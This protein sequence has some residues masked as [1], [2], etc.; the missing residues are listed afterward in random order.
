MKNQNFVGAALLIA[1]TFAVSSCNKD[2]FATCDLI[3]NTSDSTFTTYEYNAD[4]NIAKVSNTDQT[5]TPNTI[6]ATAYTYNADK[7]MTKSVQTLNGV[8]Q[9]ANEYT[10]NADGNATL[11]KE[12]DGLGALNATHNLRYNADKLLAVDSLVD[13][14]GSVI[15]ATY[16]YDTKKNVTK[17]AATIGTFGSI[18]IDYSNYDTKNNPQGLLRGVQ[19]DSEDGLFV[20]PTKSPNNALKVVITSPFGGATV[21]N[22]ISEYNKKGFPTKFSSKED[23]NP[24]VNSTNT[25][26]CD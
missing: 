26:T 22:T 8:L 15:K 25:Y 6:V 2:P 10:Y 12:T 3:K 21:V 5:T 16:T 4:G 7:K 11:I 19:Y 13:A 23:T 9:S 20:I 1:A 14:S 18:S 17:I 24:A